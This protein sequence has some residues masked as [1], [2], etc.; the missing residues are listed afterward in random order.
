MGVAARWRSASLRSLRG[1]GDVEL[2][3]VGAQHRFARFA[4][5]VTLSCNLW[6]R[7]VAVLV[8]WGRM[9]LSCGLWM[10][11]LGG[12]S[13]LCFLGIGDSCALYDSRRKFVGAEFIPPHRCNS[14]RAAR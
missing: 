6:V 1:A 13:S 4:G 8:P 10:G 7:G 2:G 3:A 9:S 12:D 14:R 11:Q 5:R